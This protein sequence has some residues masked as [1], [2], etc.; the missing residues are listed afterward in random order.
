MKYDTL[1]PFVPDYTDISQEEALLLL[2][3]PSKIEWCKNRGR[4]NKNDEIDI[5]NDILQQLI[6]AAEL[7]RM[8]KNKSLEEISD[9]A[10]RELAK[11][12]KA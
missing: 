5:N 7:E 2:A 8:T 9:I 10:T 3:E 1:A 12:Q 6:E 4:I 11:L